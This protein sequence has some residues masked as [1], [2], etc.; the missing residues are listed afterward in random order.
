MDSSLGAGSVAL[1]RGNQQL[2]SHTIGEKGMQ[3]RMLVPT[4]QQCLASQKLEASQLSTIYCTIGPGGFT[5]IRIALAA[6]R[7]LGFTLDIPVV[8]VSTLACMA[9]ESTQQASR[10]P[11]IPAGRGNV[12]AQTFSVDL[13]PTA[14]PALFATQDLTAEMNLLQIENTAIHGLSLDTQIIPT[15]G[16][17]SIGRLITHPSFA[18]HHA[19]P[20]EPLYIRPPDAKLPGGKSPPSPA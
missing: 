11:I 19:L 4:I 17:Q 10:T 1:Y 3:A 6:A 12:Y 18:A 2:A 16:A 9:V 5:G 7:A 15:I 13:L 14:P 20:A 8:G